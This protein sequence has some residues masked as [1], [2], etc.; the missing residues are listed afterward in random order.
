MTTCSFSFCFESRIRP[1][2]EIAGHYD[3]EDE[4]GLVS[5]AARRTQSHARCAHAVILL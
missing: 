3:D 5:T 1:G 4:G 2:E